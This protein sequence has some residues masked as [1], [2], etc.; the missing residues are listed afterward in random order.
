[1]EC[2]W[3]SRFRKT[4]EDTRLVAEKR[5]FE[6]INSKIDGFLEVSDYNWE[7][8]TANNLASVYLTGPALDP[9]LKGSPLLC[10]I[11]LILTWHSGGLLSK[12]SMTPALEMHLP[13]FVRE[14]RRYSVPAIRIKKF[15]RVDMNDAILILEKLK[16]FDTSYF[17]RPH[18]QKS[19]SEGY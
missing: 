10:C 8:T 4:F 6:I 17:Q 14:L 12:N 15:S 19:N 13:S 18:L 9:K 3:C 7:A 16:N 2:E 5:L 1:M 11:H